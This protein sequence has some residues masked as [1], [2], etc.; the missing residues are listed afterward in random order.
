MD[1]IMR[2][3]ARSNTT[4]PCHAHDLWLVGVAQPQARASSSVGLKDQLLQP[5]MSAYGTSNCAKFSNQRCCTAYL[6]AFVCWLHYPLMVMVL[7]TQPLPPRPQP[8]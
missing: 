7:H 1:G 8:C 2:S 5:G 6:C 3:L 4:L